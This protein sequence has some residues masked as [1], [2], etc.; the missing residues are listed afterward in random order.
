MRPGDSQREDAYLDREPYSQ[1]MERFL[2][3]ETVIH[4]IDV[5]GYLFG[6]YKVFLQFCQ[7]LTKI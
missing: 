3:H 1:K 4:F 6:V 5:H 7:D 2:I